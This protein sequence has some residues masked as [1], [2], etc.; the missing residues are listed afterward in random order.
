VKNLNPF[1][2]VLAKTFFYWGFAIPKNHNADFFDF[3]N[4]KDERLSHLEYE[5]K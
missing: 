3:F 1:Y 4:F 5:N 2:V